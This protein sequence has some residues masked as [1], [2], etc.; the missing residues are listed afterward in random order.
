[1]KKKKTIFLTGATGLLG[2]YLL[3]I[4]IEKGHKVYALVRSKNNK[5][6]EDRVLGL[7]QNILFTKS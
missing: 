5:S 3:K 4:L 2:S 6:A 1:M 7:V